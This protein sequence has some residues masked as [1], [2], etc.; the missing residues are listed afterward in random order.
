[1][2]ELKGLRDERR[3]LEEF[4]GEL[5]KKAKSLQ[6]KAQG[7]RAAGKFWLFTEVELKFFTGYFWSRMVS[8]GVEV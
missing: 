4:R 6:I 5:I 1:M 7:K 8:P 3:E 2:L